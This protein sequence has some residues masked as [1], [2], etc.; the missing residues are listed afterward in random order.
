LLAIGRLDA[1]ACPSE[2]T[3]A[4]NLHTRAPLAVQDDTQ[5]GFLY[6]L[7]LARD[8]KRAKVA[9]TEPCHLVATLAD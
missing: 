1:T 8:V 3:M 7:D 9:R 5:R 6:L 4:F 2:Q